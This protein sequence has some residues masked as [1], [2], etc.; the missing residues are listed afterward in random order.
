MYTIYRAILTPLC[1]IL[2]NLGA[3]ALSFVWFHLLNVVVHNPKKRQIY[4]RTSICYT[5]R[6]FIFLLCALH[7]IKVRFEHFER[8]D[9]SAGLILVANHPS[10]IDY[11]LIA[12]RLKHLNCV[13]KEQ[14][15]HNFFL[16]GIIKA[17]GY[18]ANDDPEGFLQQGSASLAQGENLLIFPEG[19][20]TS[21]QCELRL[22]RGAAALAVHSGHPLQVI[23]ISLSTEFL[24]KE[25]RWYHVPKACPQYVLRVGE[26]LYDVPATATTTVSTCTALSPLKQAA[27]A[28]AR[29]AMTEAVPKTEPA[30]VPE[31]VPEEAL[32]VVPEAAPEAALEV[33]PEAAPEAALETVPPP[34]A[35]PL[36]AARRTRRL[37]HRLTAIMK[38]ASKGNFT[39][40]T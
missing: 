40:G 1:F 24:S 23:T 7:L 8:L 17:A 4:A 15:K 14:L 36:S 19:T 18:L 34:D 38:T 20:R 35:E 5:F 29:A 10:L 21:R 33:V 28:A 13:V 26:R 22:R 9:S 31:A 25:K 39:Y 11:V 30:A 27:S 16:R 32:E 2:F 37:N 3:L 12:S 6:G